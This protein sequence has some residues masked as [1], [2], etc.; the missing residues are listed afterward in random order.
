[1]ERLAELT[2]SN[3]RLAGAVAEL[4]AGRVQLTEAERMGAERL[5]AAERSHTRKRTISKLQQADR[6]TLANLAAQAE[7]HISQP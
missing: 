6:A 2:R 3:E 7:Q 1:M 5:A 4:E